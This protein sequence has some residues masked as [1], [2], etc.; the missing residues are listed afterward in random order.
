[1][2]ETH[3]VHG[4]PSSSPTPQLTFSTITFDPLT[5]TATHADIAFE[6]SFDKI[7]PLNIP[8]IIS[9]TPMHDIPFTHFVQP[10][11]PL[12]S[13]SFQSPHSTSSVESGLNKL[14][15]AVRTDFVTGQ[16]S[17]EQKGTE[18]L[19]VRMQSEKI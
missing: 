19:W 18:I 9:A 7:P 8:S 1:M 4:F 5:S 14:I 11:T 17:L 13:Q 6:S 15:E 12:P 10:S 3:A 16:S 2:T